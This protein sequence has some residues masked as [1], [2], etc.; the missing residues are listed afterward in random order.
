MRLLAT[1]RRV[2]LAGLGAL[3]SAAAWT[4]A[5][6][7]I[8]GATLSGT[9][10][11]EGGDAAGPVMIKL[12][13]D[14]A[15]GLS[16]DSASYT[17]VNLEQ[18]IIDFVGSTPD[19]FANDFAVTER[20]LTTAEAAT[21]AANGRSFA[22]VPFV[23]SPVALMTLVPN[24]TYAGT[25]TIQPSQ[26]CQ[27]IPLS[28]DQLD[29]IYGAA[30]P[31]Y[32]GW[33]DARLSCTAPPNTPADSLLFGRWANLDP[34]MENFAV[35]SLL[36]STDASK[37]AFAAGLVAATTQASTTDP[38]ASEH[39]PYS[40]TAVT[41]GDQATLGKLIGLDPRTGAP[42][43][44]ATQ[45]SLGAIMPVA[46]E[47]TGD[48]LGVRWDLPTAAVQ[49]AQGSFVAPTA[50]SAEAAEADATFASTSDPTTNNLVTFPASATDATAYNNYLMMESYLVVPTNG[51]SADKALALAQFIRFAVGTKGQADIEALGAAPA[52]TQ[53][54]AADLKVAQQLDAEA[55]AD[56]PA[57]TT[58][59]TTS[60][61]ST[62]TTVA[63]AGTATSGA[64]PSTAAGT[65][66]SSGGG[67]ALTGGNPVPLAGL[68]LVLL[69][70]GEASRQVL[71]RRK[72]KA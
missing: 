67:L 34:T 43:S 5:S 69:V 36:D 38:T 47:W 68:G 70:C 12:I 66:G 16:P 62:T 7:S 3:V 63:D 15:A 8:A 44:K 20:P 18:G 33:G 9:V 65:T 46:S 53:M 19:T 1:R 51:L 26:F 24:S 21:A 61:S 50:A 56:P 10:S 31:Q 32:T 48:P 23:A 71:R 57:S 41:G 4:S 60:A 25:T 13:H 64:S 42:S 27:H 37:A 30:T 58:T 22:Y 35:M 39:W 6:P 54:V 40:G 2:L 45:L 49:N 72:R 28:L 55:A 59:T 14:D 11:G 17:N 52:T 29:G